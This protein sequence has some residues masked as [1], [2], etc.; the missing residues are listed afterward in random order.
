MSDIITN[1]NYNNS[2]MIKFWQGIRYLS[3]NYYITCGTTINEQGVVNIGSITNYN[4]E[5]NYTVTFP[6]S[7]VT[8]VYGPDYVG[9]GV[10]RLVGTYRN[11]NEKTV[12]GF[13]FEGTLI[14]LSKTQNY[15]SILIG[16]NSD[17]TYVHST[18]GNLIGGTYGSNSAAI[19]AFIMKIKT[20]TV[21]NVV[22]PGSKS[23]TVYGIWYNEDDSYTLCG[24]YSDE[25]VSA[26]SIYIN[27]Q[28]TPFGKAYL[29]NYNSITNL[30]SNWTSFTYKNSNLLT[31]FEGI[32][33]S[34]PKKYEISADAINY[35]NINIGSFVTIIQNKN[36]EFKAHDWINI[37]YP[38]PLTI[39]S[40]NSV[41]NNIIVGA[42]FDSQQNSYGYS[43]EINREKELPLLD[44]I[45]NF[46][47]DY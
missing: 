10:Y 18:M 31:H 23:N 1:V 30:F 9:I 14:D 43:A 41:A 15:N 34:S 28:P 45:I 21:I 35:N 17:Y 3:D 37:D 42:Y 7:E 20:G 12:Y 6:N 44:K 38:L 19:N 13:F 16:S 33:S 40:S 46:I 22:F 25:E 36:G 8:S 4:S 24:G 32:S 29:V 11:V 47:N 5:N 26:L 2:T 39:T 27:G